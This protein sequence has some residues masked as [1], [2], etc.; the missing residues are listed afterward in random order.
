MKKLFFASV[1]FV[2]VFIIIPLILILLGKYRVDFFLSVPPSA[3][4][5]KLHHLTNGDSQKEEYLFFETK[6][7]TH[8]M[9]GK[10]IELCIQLFDS[11]GS[12]VLFKVNKKAV[13]LLKTIKIPNNDF[14]ISKVTM[15]KLCALPDDAFN[16]KLVCRAVITYEN[17]KGEKIQDDK[18][19]K[20]EILIP[21]TE[22]DDNSKEEDDKDNDNQNTNNDNNDK[23]NDSEGNG[24][25]LS[26]LIRNISGTEK[27]ATLKN[28]YVDHN[29]Y[30]DGK[31][32]MQITVEYKS[33]NLKDDILCCMVSF[34]NDDGSFLAHKGGD[35]QYR[36]INGNVIVYEFTSPPYNRCDTKTTL[37]IPYSELPQKDKRTEFLLDARILHY[38]TETDYEQLD[39]GKTY[40][41]YLMGD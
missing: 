6:M 2:G 32:G 28:L 26:T 34:Y 9:Q 41:F 33:T 12:P 27:S 15:I 8:N 23:N 4:I 30:K 25:F 1:L 20:F 37:F 14:V 7:K 10:S 35:E 29:I 13:K 21:D 36:S 3:V 18:D 38:T 5:S 11:D 39:R 22:D 40:S 31:K 24:S 16:K 19:V 17:D